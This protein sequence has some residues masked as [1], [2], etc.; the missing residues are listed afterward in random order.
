MTDLAQWCGEYVAPLRGRH[1][2]IV[3]NLTGGF[4]SLQGFMQTLGM[5]YADE[6][7]Y[8]FES[9]ESLM[10]IPRL[11][12]DIDSGAYREIENHFD[13]YRKL[14]VGAPVPLA[15]FKGISESMLFTDGGTNAILSA[16]G[17]IFWDRF[18]RT[19]YETKLHPSPIPEIVISDSFHKD[20]EHWK[21]DKHVFFS[22]NQRLDD[23]AKYLLSDRKV[24]PKRLDFKSITGDLAKEMDCTHEFD[25]WSTSGAGRGFCRFIDKTQIEAVHLKPHR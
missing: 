7:F 9:S 21:G 2:E 13:T 20:I 18:T 23:L 12:I 11:P 1:T 10:R 14:S 6:T 3:F 22:V 15:A 8:L 5:F 24:C 17:E 4:K 16:W 25:V 19:F